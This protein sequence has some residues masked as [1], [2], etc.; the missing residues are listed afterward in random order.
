MRSSEARFPALIAPA[1]LKRGAHPDAR[2]RNAQFSGAYCAG[3]IE[4]LVSHGLKVQPP[5]FSGAYCA[6]LIEASSAETASTAHIAGFSGAYCAGLIEAALHRPRAQPL[7]LGFPAL[8]APA[9]L[10]LSDADTLDD[11]PAKFSGAYCAGL[12]EARTPWGAG[13]TGREGF[14]ALIAPAS[15][16]R[17]AAPHGFL[18]ARQFS[19]AYCA[20][21]I[22]APAVVS[23]T[24]RREPVFR[25]L[26]RRPH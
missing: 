17:A 10:K 1:S 3:L 19:G 16:K 25:R 15:L 14:P 22:E 2:T 12:I 4:A 23:S 7:E 11:S 20:G 8:I 24:I 26:L 5:S 21:L 6:G 18:Q 13:R 9:S